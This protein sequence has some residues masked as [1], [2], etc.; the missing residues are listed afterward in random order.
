MKVW[1]TNLLK[2]NQPRSIDLFENKTKIYQSIQEEKKKQPEQK[3]F[4]LKPIKPL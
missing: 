2:E 1:F 4:Q 3:K